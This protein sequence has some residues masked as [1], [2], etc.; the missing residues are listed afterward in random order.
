MGYK[1]IK[2]SDSIHDIAAMPKTPTVKSENGYTRL[3]CI[4]NQI[5]KSPYLLKL[6]VNMPVSISKLSAVV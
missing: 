4:I 1:V 2:N 6:H 5:V 3:K